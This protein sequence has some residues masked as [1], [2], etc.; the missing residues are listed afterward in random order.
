[1]HP[2]SPSALLISGIKQ[3]PCL[4]ST[5]SKSVKY[6]TLGK[7]HCAFRVNN[8][9]TQMK[10]GEY[11]LHWRIY[12]A[13]I[14]LSS[15]VVCAPNGF[16]LW[17]NSMQIASLDFWHNTSWFYMA[18]WWER[19]G[20]GVCGS[21]TLLVYLLSQ[22]FF[23]VSLQKFKRIFIKVHPFIKKLIQVL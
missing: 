20:Q 10:N 22:V 1:M 8:T 4:V 15:W 19:E 16:D 21:G 14:E 17:T 2:P 23:S 12:L 11:Y 7:L 5:P 3:A 9:E 13:A 6:L 18:Y